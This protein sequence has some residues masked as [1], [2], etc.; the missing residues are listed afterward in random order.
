MLQKFGDGLEIYRSSSQPYDAIPFVAAIAAGLKMPLLNNLPE[1]VPQVTKQWLAYFSFKIRN[2]L[3]AHSGD[4][5]VM[6]RGD[7]NKDAQ[8]A[9]GSREQYLNFWN[10]EDH[11]VDYCSQY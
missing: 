2:H 3:C 6:A 1:R 9:P 10:G 11:I 4:K 7:K 5:E 8:G